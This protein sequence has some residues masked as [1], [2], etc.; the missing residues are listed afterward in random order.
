MRRTL[1][2][3]LAIV[4]VTSTA[5]AQGG[6][7]GVYADP[8]GIDCHPQDTVVG[9]CTYYVVHTN[10]AGATASQFKAAQPICHL[11]TYLS[12][13]AIFPVT[14]GNSQTGVAV[15]YGACLLSPIDVLHLNF[16]CAQITPPCCAYSVTPDPNV[17]S[18][19][20]EVVDCV[21]ALLFGTG[22][23]TYVNGN[24][25]DCSCIVATEETTWGAVKSIYSTE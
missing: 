4:C 3:S 11:A 13:T 10:I 16:F 1:L 20:I 25:I 7:L 2:I 15:G 14:I 9:L 23:T 12:D 8:Q 19:K 18:G 5:F 21:N 24:Q 6:T 22:A 17:A